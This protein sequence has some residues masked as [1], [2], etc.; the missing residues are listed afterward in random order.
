MKK[1]H[2]LFTLEKRITETKEVQHSKK[3]NRFATDINSQRTY[4]P[5]YIMIFLIVPSFSRYILSSYYVRHRSRL[6]SW[7]TVGK[8]DKVPGF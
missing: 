3:Y 6:G 7:D 5:S 1:F 8:Q 2:E 4:F